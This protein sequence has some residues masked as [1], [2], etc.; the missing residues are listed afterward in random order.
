MLRSV[1]ASG[2][3][4]GCLIGCA[5]MPVANPFVAMRP[6]YETVPEA[7][8]RAL[9]LEIERAVMAGDRSYVPTP[10]P[11]VQAGTEEIL[12]AIRTRAARS[13]MLQEFLNT[14]FGYER[15]NGLVEI[16]RS[17]AYRREGTRQDRDRNAM[18]VMSENADRWTLY[19][20]IRNESRFPARS[21]SAIQA[22]FFEARLEL[23]PSGRM[24]EDAHGEILP[25]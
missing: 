21:L 13:E 11:G 14:G 20:G 24:Y 1:I 6:D 8:L 22:I 2:L 17:S 4:L 19:E 23:M 15:R 3:V 9:A 12:H 25:R 18:L 7:E 5:S 16:Q 10:V